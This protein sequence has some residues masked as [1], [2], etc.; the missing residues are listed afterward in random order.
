M[1]IVR[2]AIVRAHRHGGI[3]WLDAPVL[4][5]VRALGVVLER[6]GRGRVVEHCVRGLVIEEQEC[7]LLASL[8]VPADRVPTHNL[9]RERAA[10]SAV[11]CV[12][13]AGCSAIVVIGTREVDRRGG[14]LDVVDAARGES[15]VTVRA[16][17][18]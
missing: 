3:A 8:W 14:A 4:C 5:L 17:G 1:T 13:A 11:A 12:C 16:C 2:A 6:V 9:A 10:G 7:Q 15:R 18:G